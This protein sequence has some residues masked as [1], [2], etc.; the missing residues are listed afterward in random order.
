MKPKIP[1]L[2]EVMARN[3]IPASEDTIFLPTDIPGVEKTLR[4]CKRCEKSYT[5]LAY[6]RHVVTSG[7]CVP[8]GEL[9]FPDKRRQREEEER[10]R[11]FMKEC[12]IEYQRCDR[13]KLPDPSKFDEVS[14][15]ESRGRSLLLLGPS[16][17][18]KTRLGWNTVKR[19]H[20]HNGYDF[21][22]TSDVEL[23]HALSTKKLVSEIIARAINA[24][25]LLWDDLGKTY[26]ESFISALRLILEK[27]FS[28]QRTTIITM[29]IDGAA[30]ASK[31]A[32]RTDPE[33]AHSL[34]NRLRAHCDLIR[35]KTVEV[36]A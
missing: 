31:I 10:L 33:Q 35:F 13:A 12:P 22:A 36:Q 29:Q 28:Q 21:Y 11:N 26:S 30:W 5:A 2:S 4:M 20:V 19:L 32:E 17:L 18:G 7:Y 34:R 9:L 27:R 1:T 8:C 24:R 25:V 16:N 14:A 6:R 15:W 23:T 3:S